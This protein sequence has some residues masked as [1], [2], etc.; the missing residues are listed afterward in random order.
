[1]ILMKKSFFSKTSDENERTSCWND[2][3]VQCCDTAANE[4]KK[5]RKEKK[6]Q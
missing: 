4:W 1:M 2:F 6:I 5:E 3:S